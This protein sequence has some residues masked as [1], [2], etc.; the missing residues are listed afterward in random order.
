MCS[1]RAGGG[2]G[3]PDSTIGSTVPDGGRPATVEFV[4]RADVN[5]ISLEYQTAGEPAADPL[6]LI[7]GLGAQLIAWDDDLVAALVGEGLYVVRFDNRDVGLSTWLDEAGTPD[8]LEALAGRAAAPYLVEDMADDAAGLI[9]A[10]GLGSAH[11]LGA[12]MG[13]MIAQSLAIRHSQKVRTLVSIMSTTGNPSVGAPHPDAVAVLL[14]AP[15]VGRD[16]AVER[17][18]DIARVIGSPGYPF[19]EQRVR[20]E[21]GDAYDRAFH[22]QGV[23]RQAVAVVCSPDRTPGLRRLS[24][25]ALVI[26][27]EDDPLVDVSG[28]RATAQA[29]PGASLWT[30]PG[31]GH[32]LP[33]ALFGEVARRVGLLARGHS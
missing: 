8:A 11:V 3:E 27:G 19:A 5:G 1:W 4:P 14:Q 23:A 22:P 33:P 20:Q 17:A 18:V 7:M 12:S 6:L 28:G 26:H 13:G 30:V 2:S 31:M 16:E 9:D 32:D 10:L 21:A 15:P 24:V 25:P 29:I